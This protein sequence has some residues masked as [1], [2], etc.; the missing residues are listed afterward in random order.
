MRSVHAVSRRFQVGFALAAACLVATSCA[1]D[2]RSLVDSPVYSPVPVSTLVSR[3]DVQFKLGHVQ[4]GACRLTVLAVQDPGAEPSPVAILSA[5]RSA[6]EAH[7]SVQRLSLPERGDRSALHVATLEHL[8]ALALQQEPEARFGVGEAAQ[9]CE[10]ATDGSSHAE[11]LRA[12][13]RERERA[14]AEAGRA[15]TSVPW[16]VVSM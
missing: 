7:V 3:R 2:G 4:R 13:A 9:P 6:D 14:I 15:S 8:Y 10:A 5:W 11:L 16:H 1:A 12:L